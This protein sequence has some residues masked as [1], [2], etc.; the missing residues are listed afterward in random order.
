MND[1]NDFVFDLIKSPTLIVD[2][3]IVRRNLSFM[4]SKCV[5]KTYLRPHF[6]T[7]NNTAIGRLIKEYNVEK[8][9]VSSIEMAQKFADIFNDILIAFPYNIRQTEE[10]NSLAK[11]IN[12]GICISNLYSAETLAKE[13][14]SE[15]EV[16]IEID[17]GY[18]RSG[19]MYNDFSEIEATIKTLQ[20]GDFCRFKGFLTHNGK[21]YQ[22]K[23]HK[24][25]LLSGKDSIKKMLVLKNRYSEYNPIISVGD[26]PYCSIA[27]DFANIDELRPG[28]FIYYDL[29]QL[30]AGICTIE[31]IAVRVFCPIVDINANRAQAVIYGGAIHFSKE[32]TIVNDKYIYGKCINVIADQ[33]INVNADLISLSQ[34]H[35]ILQ[36][37]EE[38][39]PLIYPGCLAEIIPVHSCLTANLM[40]NNTIVL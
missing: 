29:M 40:E 19:I 7:H 35:G 22:L 32:S 18:F 39:I 13:L 6:K 20:L 3:N 8:I 24:S 1:L 12:L 26:T 28:N 15:A 23:S 2:S 16:Y 34:E 37:S 31:D 21:S 4:Q 30:L 27:K 5:G 17:T 9:C 36:F 11:S 10:F 33:R 38:A 14:S 25:I